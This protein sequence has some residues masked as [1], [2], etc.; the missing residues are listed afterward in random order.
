MRLKLT[1]KGANILDWRTS[2]A[3]LWPSLPC[4]FWRFV[5]GPLAMPSCILGPAILDVAGEIATKACACAEVRGATKSLRRSLALKR[6]TQGSMHQLWL[7]GP[8]VGSD[9]M[10]THLGAC[11]V[12]PW[13]CQRD[14]LLLAI[15][16]QAA[17]LESPAPTISAE[18]GPQVICS[19]THGTS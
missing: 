12:M 7:V 1:R 11:A 4:V 5:T 9:G 13:R 8:H 19:K 14:M 18:L 3:E 10:S 15:H 17:Y 6:S 16:D 2:G